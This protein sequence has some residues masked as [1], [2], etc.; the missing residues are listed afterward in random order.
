MTSLSMWSFLYEVADFSASQ[1]ISLSQKQTVS[2]TYRNMFMCKLKPW[3]KKGYLQNVTSYSW[4]DKL[5]K[6]NI[7]R[8]RALHTTLCPVLLTGSLVWTRWF[9]QCHVLFYLHCCRFGTVA[10]KT[11]KWHHWPNDVWPRPTEVM[12]KID[13]L[14]LVER[15]Q[16]PNAVCL[17]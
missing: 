3:L 14:S 12:L 11:G 13:V 8:I 2:E 6:W 16:L 10:R 4:F 15:V 1:Y 9:F 5:T 17:L 7:A